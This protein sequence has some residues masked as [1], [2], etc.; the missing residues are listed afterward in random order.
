MVLD[1]KLKDLLLHESERCT[2]YSDRL[3]A[4]FVIR[5]GWDFK[6]RCNLNLVFLI[7]RELSLVLLWRH[8]GLN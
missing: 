5:F 2:F 4:E 1:A 6:L 8:L 3:D 7:A